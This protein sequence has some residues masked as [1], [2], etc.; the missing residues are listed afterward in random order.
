MSRSNMSRPNI[1]LQRLPPGLETAMMLSMVMNDRDKDRGKNE[2]EKIISDSS[3]SIF[4]Q[5]EKF[6]DNAEK[7][8]VKEKKEK[9]EEEIIINTYEGIQFV[10]PSVSEDNKCS[11]CLN[12]YF[13]R[14]TLIDR[15]DDDI[16]GHS[17]CKSCIHQ[18]LHNKS[19]CPLCKVDMT[20]DNIFSIPG[21]KRKIYNSIVRCPHEECKWTGKLGKKNKNYTDHLKICE[22]RLIECQNDNCS[23]MV[24]K[25]NIADHLSECQF[26]HCEF[27]CQFG[28]GFEATNESELT[29]H[30]SNIDNM[31]IHLLQLNTKFD[32]LLKAFHLQNFEQ[33]NPLEYKFKDMDVKATW[34]KDTSKVYSATIQ[35]A[36]VKND[37]IT[38][39]L[40]Y[41]DGD[42]DKKAPLQN[43]VKFTNDSEKDTEIRNLL[44]QKNLS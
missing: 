8:E 17:F 37:R 19:E 2:P 42:I 1:P 26:T 10:D 12:V 43:I 18:S 14:V 32:I 23:E 13:D 21:E 4:E 39:S 27:T 33:T 6:V 3:L 36:T 24:R 40:K 44:N 9:K 15:D 38:F 30:L 20:C 28:C 31:L 25:K 29:E 35:K 11:I 34:K 22:E 5:V 41:Y 7:S 16:C